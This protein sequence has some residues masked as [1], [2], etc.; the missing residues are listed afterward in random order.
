MSANPE[1]DTRAWG[2]LAHLSSLPGPFG[3]GTMGREAEDFLDLL[4]VGKARYWQILP[5]GPTSPVFGHSP[6]SAVSAFAGNPFFINLEAVQSNSW[7]PDLNLASLSVPESHHVDFSAAIRATEALQLA[8]AGFNNHATPEEQQRFQTYQRDQLFWL[9]DYALFVVLSRHFQTGYWPSWPEELRLRDPSAITRARKKFANE[10]SVEAFLQFLFDQQWNRLRQQAGKRG[11]RIVGDLPI[12]VNMDSA[13]T[14]SNPSVFD[15]APLTRAPNRV[16][17]VP[18]DYFSPTGQLWGNPLYRWQGPSGLVSD[19]SDW[20]T[21]RIRN[22]LDRFDVIR[23]DHFRGFAGYWAVPASA[24]TAES[25]SWEKGPGISFFRELEQR[26]GPLPVIAEDLGEITPDVEALRRELGF[27][28]MKILQFAFDGDGHNIHLPHNFTS[29]NTVVYTGTHDNNTLNGWFYGPENSDASREYIRAY[30]N[31]TNPHD[32]H[33][34]LTRLALQSVARL[35]IVPVQ[36]LLGYGAECRMNVP[37]RGEGNW[38]W[39][40]KSQSLSAE[41]MAGMDRIC[42][43][44]GRT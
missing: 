2:V 42:H 8:F 36:D 15:L 39:K 30:L 10:I 24:P 4:T 6:Y 44:Y 29:P 20:W 9:E 21:L 11:I 13:D 1:K 38:G 7:C 35:A 32:M 12:Y 41:I 22:A 19:T 31:A 33:L 5:L 16:A 18:P 17:G 25:G 28:G 37:G 43:L 14:W 34:P 27:P 23:L 26:L 3:I 40:W